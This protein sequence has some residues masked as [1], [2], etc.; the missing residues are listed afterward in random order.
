VLPWAWVQVVP[1][2]RCCMC[3]LRAWS[4]CLFW[5]AASHAGAQ[6]HSSVLGIQVQ[7]LFQA[8]VCSCWA[9]VPS[10]VE[11]HSQVEA[12]AAC[13]AS[14]C[15]EV[16][17]RPAVLCRAV[18]VT[19]LHLEWNLTTSCAPLVPGRLHCACLPLPFP[20]WVHC[21]LGGACCRWAQVVLGTSWC[22]G[23]WAGWAGGTPHGQCLP[24]L[25]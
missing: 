18:Q 5:A 13:S 12:G 10:A 19:C 11:V 23:G 24:P 6:V 16:G 2:P 7:T 15:L 22:P 1:S 9:Q 25:F 17:C 3:R 14:C 20:F 4:G 8:A 21:T